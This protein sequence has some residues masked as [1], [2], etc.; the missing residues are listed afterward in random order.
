MTAVR[1]N[2]ARK[3]KYMQSTKSANTTQWHI[4][5][6]TNLQNWVNIHPVNSNV[7][8]DPPHPRLILN[9]LIFWRTWKLLETQ[10]V[11]CLKTTQNACYAF[12]LP[13][14]SCSLPFLP[15]IALSHRSMTQ[16]GRYV[17]HQMPE[18]ISLSAGKARYPKEAI[19][20]PNL[21]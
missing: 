2:S 15:T 21:T 9:L 8:V 5:Y 12:F 4:T 17:L 14:H 11:P 13:F 7:Y 20:P 18:R 6:L 3:K 16:L 1:I 19:L 10:L